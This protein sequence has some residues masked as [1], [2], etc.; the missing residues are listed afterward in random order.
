MKKLFAFLLAT[1]LVFLLVACGP[2]TDDPDSGKKD[3]DTSDTGNKNSPIG[4]NNDPIDLPI[5][6]LD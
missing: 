2:K 4:D 5:V 3:P 6:D 1:S